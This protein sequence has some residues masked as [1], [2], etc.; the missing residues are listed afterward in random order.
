[1]TARLA[2]GAISAET[3]RLVTELV[4]RLLP[5]GRGGRVGATWPWHPPRTLLGKTSLLRFTSML[6]CAAGQ[7]GRALLGLEMACAP[8]AGDGERGGEDSGSIFNG[9]FRYA[10]TLGD[11][12]QALARYFPV[13]QTGTTV[14]LRQAHGRA[15]LS[16]DIH[17][18]TVSDRLQDAAF[19]LGRIERALRGYAGAAWTLDEVTL[20]APPP[21]GVEPY[22]RF[23]RSPVFFGAP[24]SA[25]C[26]PARLLDLPV[27]TVDIPRYVNVCRRLHRAMPATHEPDLLEDALHAWLT[28]A[29]PQGQ[30]TLEQAAAD[31]GITPRTLQRRLRDQ[32]IGFQ[33]LLATVRMETA[34]RLLAESR[35]T[36]TQIAVQL[37]FSET[38]A[39]TRAFRSHTRLSPRAYRGKTRA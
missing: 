26:F 33:S 28:Q 7:S 39:F 21:S 12:L 4:E 16:Y 17:D 15:Y 3:H 35:L 2:V 25:L 5:N 9:L 29:A 10:P 32:G 11:G 36:V 8:L 19:T 31:F 24:S 27:S 18:P 38:S 37:G 23:F 13:V 22:R 6:A 20:S 34:Q 30:A 1:M 14:S